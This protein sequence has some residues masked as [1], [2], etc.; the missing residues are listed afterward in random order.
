MKKTMKNSKK[1]GKMIMMMMMKMKMWPQKM[2]ESI[3]E[4]LPEG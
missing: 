3:Q 2:I 4:I 1:R